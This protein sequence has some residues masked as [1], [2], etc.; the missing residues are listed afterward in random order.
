[1]A[2]GAAGQAEAA[3]RQGVPAEWARL[4]GAEVRTVAGEAAVLMAVVRTVAEAVEFRTAG[5][6]KGI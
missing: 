1:M 3:E 4:T 5:T 2:A 6:E